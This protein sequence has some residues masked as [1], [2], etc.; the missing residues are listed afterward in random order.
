LRCR[1]PQ[2]LPAQVRLG[3][4]RGGPA[5]K[6]ESNRRIKSSATAAASCTAAALSRPTQSGCPRWCISALLNQVAGG[7]QVVDGE[8][9]VAGVLRNLR[10]RRPRAKGA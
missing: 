3:F 7:L 1:E 8:Q 6:R 5:G 2:P 9:A 4:E 10:Q